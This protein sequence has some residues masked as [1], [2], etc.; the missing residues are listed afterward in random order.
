MSCFFF[1]NKTENR[2]RKISRHEFLYEHVHLGSIFQT[3]SYDD[4]S[5]HANNVSA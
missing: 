2:A 5:V 1:L 3:R 4:N